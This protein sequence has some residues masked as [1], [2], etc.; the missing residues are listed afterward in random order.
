[1]RQKHQGSTKVKRAQLQALRRE[2]ELLT[3]KEGEKVDIFLGRALSMVNKMKSNGE[4]MEQSMVVSKI[5]RSLTSKYNYIVCSIEESNDLSSLTLDELH[6]SLL[7][8]EQRMQEQSVEEQVLKISQD[9][10]LGQGRG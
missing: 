1:M 2:F 5:L 7:V 4:N 9:E 3:M 6:G 8:H 10:S